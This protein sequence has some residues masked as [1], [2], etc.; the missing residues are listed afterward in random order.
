VVRGSNTKH[1]NVSSA[2]KLIA[3]CKDKLIDISA[4][5]QEQFSHSQHNSEKQH[6]LLGQR[7]GAD[8][9]RNS[10]AFLFSSP[11]AA[12]LWLLAAARRGKGQKRSV[13][14]TPLESGEVESPQAEGGEFGRRNGDLHLH[15]SIIPGSPVHDRAAEFSSSVSLTWLGVLGFSR[16]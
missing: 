8:Q 13:L 5:F 14:F 9:S 15:P 12:L 2:H 10:P 11:V 4:K 6:Q 16:V 3:R 1:T 7:A